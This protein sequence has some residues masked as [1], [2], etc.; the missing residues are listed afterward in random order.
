MKIVLVGA[1][2]VTLM[3]SPVLARSQNTEGRSHS[4]AYLEQRR[5]SGAAYRGLDGSERK[6]YGPA[7]HPPPAN[8]GLCRTAPGFCPD[9]HGSNG[10]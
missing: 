1:A 9:Y 3:A 10:G 5:Q 4:R 8:Q 7:S 6:S 2:F